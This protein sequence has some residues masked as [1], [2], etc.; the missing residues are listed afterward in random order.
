MQP[1]PNFKAGL[2]NL[3]QSFGSCGPLV[4]AGRTRLH[5]V[6]GPSPLV[7]WH[8]NTVNRID[9]FADVVFLKIG[10]SYFINDTLLCLMPLHLVSIGLLLNKGINYLMRPINGNRAFSKDH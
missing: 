2:Y 5:R 10:N 6:S 3:V 9:W 4:S 8:K 7:Q 1:S